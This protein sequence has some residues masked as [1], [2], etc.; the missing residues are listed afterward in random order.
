VSLTPEQKL[1]VA[2]MIVAQE[3]PYVASILYG[4][5]PKFQR[6]FGTMATTEHMVLIVDPDWILS[7]SDKVLAGILMHECSH[8][9]HDHLTRFANVMQG[10]SQ[11]RYLAN[12][13]MD[14]AIN[15]T[16][17]DA[18]WE[19]TP[20]ALM[21]EQYKLP[22]NKAAEWYFQE[23]RKQQP[24]SSSGGSKQKEQNGPGTPQPGGSGGGGEGSPSPSDDGSG[25]GAGKKPGVCSGGCGSITGDKANKSEL[26]KKLDAEMGRSDSDREV[27]IKL[28]ADAVKAAAQQG[29]GRLPNGFYEL[30][31]LLDQPAKIDWRAELGRISRRA[32]GKVKSGGRDFSLR[33]PS[34][35]SY[36][37]GI[38]RPGLIQQIPEVAIIRDS[39]GSMGPEQ[40]NAAT[41]EAIAI[42]K[43]L[44]IDTIWFLDAD[45]QVAFSKRLRLSELKEL[46]VHGRGG[47]SF[48]P[49]IE[50]LDKLRPRPDIAIYI[51]DGDGTAPQNAPRGVEFIWCIIPSYYKRKPA[52]WGHIVVVSET[53][54]ELAE[55]YG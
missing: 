47:T 3:A 50:A 45:A 16:L 22:R 19:L 24:K 41:I 38:M 1:S 55:P 43:A 10:Q 18:G 39:S 4:L 42:F 8:V 13:A 15:P 48:I 14:I 36:T 54:V 26:E 23:L 7:L 6:G 51:T 53:P 52:H 20:D 9:F 12:I 34:K 2:R 32:T 40:I 46:P 31:K 49:A 35:R 44:G 27:I 21:P 5:V 28:T 37:R 11:D 30:A 29:R 33:R 17:I 25:Q